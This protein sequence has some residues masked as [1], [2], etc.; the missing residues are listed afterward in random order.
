L[1]NGD[2]GVS[3]L[4]D[5]LVHDG[6]HGAASEVAPQVGAACVGAAEL[7]HVGPQAVAELGLAQVGFEHA[8]HS[9]AFAVRDGVEELR[10]LR[11]RRDLLVDGVRGGKGVRGEGAVGAGL[12]VDPH[13]QV[14]PQRVDGLVGD[15][16]REGFVEPQVVP[17]LHG[18][19]VAEPLVREFVA[20]DEGDVAFVAPPRCGAVHEEGACAEDDEARVLHGAEAEAGHGDLVVLAEAVRDAEVVGEPGL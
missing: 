18:D 4:R 20:H 9:A 16:F 17:P 14:G 13:F 1:L 2:D 3:G 15:P 11:G 7:L 8:Q 6:L 19:V 12:E 10:G 5:P